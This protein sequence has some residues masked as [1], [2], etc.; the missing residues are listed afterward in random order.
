M[1]EMHTQMEIGL[2]VKVHHFYLTATTTEMALIKMPNIKFN[3]H[4]CSISLKLSYNT[5]GWKHLNRC[6]AGP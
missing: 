3:E 5:D 6:T 4:P 2:H 1:L